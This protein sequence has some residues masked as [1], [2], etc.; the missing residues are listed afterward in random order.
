MFTKSRSGAKT[1]RIFPDYIH[2][3]DSP[4][5][6]LETWLENWLE[7]ARIVESVVRTDTNRQPTQPLC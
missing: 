1:L 6:W 3:R 2:D 5:A 4:F 7:T